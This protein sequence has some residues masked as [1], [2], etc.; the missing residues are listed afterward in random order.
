MSSFSESKM[1]PFTE[2]DFRL[3]WSMDACHQCAG[4]QL[5]AEAFHLDSRR[6]FDY[7]SRSGDFVNVKVSGRE[8]TTYAHIHD[9]GV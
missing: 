4:Q 1:V 6:H 8:N 7:D 3:P 9:A 2:N 5:A